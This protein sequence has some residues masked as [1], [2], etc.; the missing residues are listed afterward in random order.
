VD[1]V[2][3]GGQVIG[4]LGG[5]HPAPEYDTDD[6]PSPIVEHKAARE[7]CLKVYKEAVGK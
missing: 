1:I 6:Y 3:E 5:H 2:A 4:H 7:R